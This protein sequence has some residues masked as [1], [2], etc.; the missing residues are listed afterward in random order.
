MGFWNRSFLV[1]QIT[2]IVKYTVLFYDYR[3][4]S[5]LLERNQCLTKSPWKIGG[6]RS[7]GNIGHLFLGIPND[8]ST[9]TNLFSYCLEINLYKCLV[10]D[11]GQQREGTFCPGLGHFQNSFLSDSKFS[12]ILLVAHSETSDYRIP[13]KFRCVEKYVQNARVTKRSHHVMQCSD[14]S[15][16]EGVQAGSSF[17][18][19]TMWHLRARLYVLV[20][21]VRAGSKKK[22]VQP[23]VQPTV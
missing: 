6:T 8:H 1:K 18:W 5:E 19:F 4:L 23:T 22:S 21:F 3:A 7:E 9:N 13:S 16:A 12:S 2:W 17:R 11:S 10:R 15:T 14:V 20:V